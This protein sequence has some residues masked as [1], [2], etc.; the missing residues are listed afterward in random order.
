MFNQFGSGA[1]SCLFSPS[2]VC[3]IIFG[4]ICIFIIALTAIS[5]NLHNRMT[6]DFC[7]DKKVAWSD[8]TI[9]KSNYYICIAMIVIA[10]LIL[11]WRLFESEHRVE[12]VII[13]TIFAASTVG[14]IY[15]NKMQTDQQQCSAGSTPIGEKNNSFEFILSIVLL[16]LACLLLVYIIASFFMEP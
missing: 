16:S 13:F 1:G 3:R 2:P 15:H 11:A 9:V 12:W 4:I 5:I 10:C 6:G 7:K 14:I 8:S